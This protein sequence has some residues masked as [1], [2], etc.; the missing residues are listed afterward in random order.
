MVGMTYN[1]GG[2]A[3]RNADSLAN[4]GCQY[5]G[6][7]G[8][9][10]KPGIV[11]YGATWARG[12]MGNFLV[13]APN[14]CCIRNNNILFGQIFTTRSPVQYTRARAGIVHGLAGLG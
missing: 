5:G 8:G 7:C 3:A 6:S 13:R 4:R 11:T 2:K 14:G 1:S 9:N 10:K 12:N